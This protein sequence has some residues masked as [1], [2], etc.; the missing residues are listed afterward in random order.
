MV[1]KNLYIRSTVGKMPTVFLLGENM[2]YIRAA[3]SG[4]V[5]LCCEIGFETERKDKKL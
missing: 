1:G 4:G 5:F 3:P 2:V